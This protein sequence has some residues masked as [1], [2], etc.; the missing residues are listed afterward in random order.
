MTLLTMLKE[1]AGVALKN[2]LKVHGG[3]IV[4]FSSQPC[5]VLEMKVYFFSLH[6]PQSFNSVLY[7]KLELP[8]SWHFVNDDIK[9][10]LG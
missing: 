10:K 6:Y 3:L 7:Y 1:F 5:R 2:R 4:R 8:V 9:I